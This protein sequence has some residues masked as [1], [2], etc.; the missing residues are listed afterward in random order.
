ML[1]KYD[2]GAKFLIATDKILLCTIVVY[3]LLEFVVHELSGVRVF[4]RGN[5]AS[6]SELGLDI[7]WRP[8]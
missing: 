4:I 3:G 5:L 1:L 2:P 7:L 8:P 6:R